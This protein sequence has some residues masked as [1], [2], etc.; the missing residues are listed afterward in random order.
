MTDHDDRR[1]DP[2]LDQELRDQ[3]FMDEDGR[4]TDAF[5]EGAQRI[6]TC[7]DGPHAG[8]MLAIPSMDREWTQTGHRVGDDAPIDPP[9]GGIYHVEE[10]GLRMRWVPDGTPSARIIPFRGRKKPR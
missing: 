4:L 3:G 8:E 1:P 5:F 9:P 2:A 7:L 10:S 6:V